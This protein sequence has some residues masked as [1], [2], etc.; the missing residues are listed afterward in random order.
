MVFYQKIKSKKDKKIK[1]KKV[2][3][4]KRQNTKIQKDKKIKRTKKIT[5]QK[6]KKR[7][8]QKTNKIVQHC[9]VRAVSH[10]CDVDKTVLKIFWLIR[11]DSFRIPRYEDRQFH[12][13]F[14]LYQVP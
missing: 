1:N 14:F 8:R 10:S 11:T 3:V 12:P 2:K 4:T 6:E 5:R 13:C 9:D 7:K